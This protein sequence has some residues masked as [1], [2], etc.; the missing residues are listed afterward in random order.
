M[1]VW[2]G[3]PTA[4]LG[5]RSKAPSASAS[6][7]RAPWAGEKALTTMTGTSGAPFSLQGAQ[8]AEAVEAGHGEVERHGVGA[9]GAALRE[10]LVAVA[11]GAH[12]LEA[13]SAERAAED[14]A[15]E[16][17]VVGDDDAG[18]GGPSV[19]RRRSRR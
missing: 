5:T 9:R 8:H 4:G 7:A 19:A 12:H 16:R 18:G 2:K 13:G 17:R 3:S 6:T 15:H 1:K 11:G 10:R 14:G